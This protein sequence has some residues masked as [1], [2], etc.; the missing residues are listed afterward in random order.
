MSEDRYAEEGVW[1]Q[2]I[3]ELEQE[4]RRRKAEDFQSAQGPFRSPAERPQEPLPYFLIGALLLP[5][6]TKTLVTKKHLQQVQELV[7]NESTDVYVGYIL[8][9]FQALGYK[10]TCEVLTGARRYTLDPTSGGRTLFV[11]PPM[12]SVQSDTPWQVVRGVLQ[13]VVNKAMQEYTKD[14]CEILKQQDTRE[15]DY[16][17]EQVEL[18]GSAE[19]PNVLESLTAPKTDVAIVEV[20]KPPDSF[21]TRLYTAIVEILELAVFGWKSR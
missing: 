9:V 5:E 6:E 21:W 2:D 17:L 3:L 7:L 12:E 1:A 14:F 19:P 10:I 11:F 16:L 18:R 15:A 8:R 4:L 13:S 20:P